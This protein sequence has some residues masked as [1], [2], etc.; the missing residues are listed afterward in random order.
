MSGSRLNSYVYAEDFVSEPEIA[1]TA[2][3]SGEELGAAISVVTALR[4]PNEGML[5]IGPG[6]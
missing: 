6:R 5:S 1:E 2:R 4:A 3:R